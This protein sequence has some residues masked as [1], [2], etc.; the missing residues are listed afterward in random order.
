MGPR[1]GRMPHSK[2][3][4]SAQLLGIITMCTHSPNVFR[5]SHFS[6]KAGNPDF[7]SGEIW[8]LNAVN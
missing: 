3:A 6:R 7:F 8:F 1:E 5:S 4:A 2:G